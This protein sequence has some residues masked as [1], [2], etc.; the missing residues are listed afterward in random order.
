MYLRPFL[1]I[2]CQAQ[3]KS[4]FA[5]SRRRELLWKIR[6]FPGH[7]SPVVRLFHIVGLLH[8]VNRLQHLRD[9]SLALGENRLLFCSIRLALDLRL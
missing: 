6:F 9:R 7:S 1:D 8:L 5:S 2:A 4:V 3:P